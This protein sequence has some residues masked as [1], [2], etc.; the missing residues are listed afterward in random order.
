ME[1][2]RRLLLLGFLFLSWGAQAV[3]I[4]ADD[5][6]W[7]N[8]TGNHYSTN[9]NYSAGSWNTRDDAWRNFFVFDLSSVTGPITTAVFNFNVAGTSGSSVATGTYELFDVLT[10]VL[11]LVGGGT[12]LT[13]IYDDLGT[14]VSFGSLSVA[15]IDQGSVVSLNFN[16]AGLAAINSSLG[17]SFAFG[18]DLSFG[19]RIGGGS[20]NAQPT[21]LILTQGPSIPAPATLALSGLGLAGMGYLRRKQI[22]AS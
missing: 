2:F 18:G 6:G 9:T 12:G 4:S 8:K 17:G 10:P 14:G 3:T 16:S 7:Y 19:V 13:A 22:R 11:T 20:S 21:T 15:P 5:W 1:F